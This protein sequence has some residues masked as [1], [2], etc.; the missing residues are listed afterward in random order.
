[1]K[2]ASRDSNSVR[3]HELSRDGG[4][5]K[6]ED[7]MT[8]SVV[9]ILPAPSPRPRQLCH[10]RPKTTILLILPGIL[11]NSLQH[12]RNVTENKVPLGSRTPAFSVSRTPV[13]SLKRRFQSVERR[14][15]HPNAGL[16]HKRAHALRRRLRSPLRSRTGPKTP[17]ES[18]NAIKEPIRTPIS[19]VGL[20]SASAPL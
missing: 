15:S 2:S 19:F 20:F 13:Q 5:P 8:S 10:H 16:S 18:R 7:C 17:L 1:M 14:F 9:A 6:G 11:L 3:R 12:R 4:A